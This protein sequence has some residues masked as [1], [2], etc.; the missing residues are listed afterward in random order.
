MAAAALPCV[1]PQITWAQAGEARPVYRCPGPPVLYTDSLTP[2][3]ARTRQCQVIDTPAITVGGGAPRAPASAAV[4]AGTP[5]AAG[6]GAAATPAPRGET[7]V[8]PAVQ[9]SRDAQ[10][11]R[12]LEGEL[13]REEARLEALRREFAGGEPERRGDERNYARY[14][15]RVDELRAAITRAEAD[16]AAIRRELSRLAP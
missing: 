15:Q 10:A 16:V 7:R 2:E 13:R 6:Q 11:R 12:I 14:L 5:P 8:D 1:A 9:R 3:A 4:P